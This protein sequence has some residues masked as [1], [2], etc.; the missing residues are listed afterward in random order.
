M[1]ST[2]QVGITFV[3]AVIGRGILNNVVNIQLGALPFDV[4]EDGKVGSELVV[5]C[6]LRMDRLC[7]KHLRDTL[8]DLLKSI[9]RAEVETASLVANGDVRQPEEALN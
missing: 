9:D 3:N 8:D 6:R 5:A 2:D 4:T 1:K 7:A